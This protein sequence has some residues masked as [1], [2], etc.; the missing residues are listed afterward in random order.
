M[1]IYAIV[2]FFTGNVISGWTSLMTSL[3]FLG[4]IQLVGI[5]VVGEYIGKIYAEV[6]HRP[7]YIIEQDDYTPTQ[8]TAQ[9]NEM[10]GAS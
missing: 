9:L 2:R 3:W 8:Q 5:S 6:K 10:V 7:R 1:V 4:G